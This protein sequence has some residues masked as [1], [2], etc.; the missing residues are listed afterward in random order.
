MLKSCRLL[1]LLSIMHWCGQVTLAQDMRVYTSVTDLSRGPQSS[2]VLSTSLTLFHA[3]KVYDYM[4]EIGEVVI[5]E[6]GHH[7]FIIL[8]KD[9]AA[10]EVPFA[11]LNHFLEAAQKESLKYIEELST[12]PDTR[13]AKLAI[14]VRFQLQPEFLQSFDEQ[15]TTLRLQ[16]GPMNYEVRVA[17]APTTQVVDRYLDYTDWAARLNYVLHPHSAFPAARLIL[18]D[19]LRKR[20]QLPVQVDRS[21]QVEGTEKLRAQHSFSWEFQSID[22]K[23][24]S[25]WERML[26]SDKVRWLTFHEYQQQVLTQQA[27]AASAASVPRPSGK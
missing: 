3:G 18:N 10:T 14:A 25:H 9:F 8:G 16:G 22:K 26:Q 13:S 7:R 23:H 20:K 17:S 19:A 5:Y 2:G 27:K 15:A 21:L 4:E 6:P 12:R 11:E 24:I 1:A